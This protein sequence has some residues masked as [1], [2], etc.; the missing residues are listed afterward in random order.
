MDHK[1]RLISFF[2]QL[3]GQFI[4]VQKESLIVGMIIALD[5]KYYEK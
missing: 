5:I 1:V 4:T 3:D 2:Q